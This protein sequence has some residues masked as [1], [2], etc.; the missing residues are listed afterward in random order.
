[1]WPQCFSF[2]QHASVSNPVY[3]GSSIIYDKIVICFSRDQPSS[4]VVK[5]IQ[6]V[7]SCRGWVQEGDALKLQPNPKPK[8]VPKVDLD[9]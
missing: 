2:G 5:A 3:V 8:S 9:Q 7:S 1:M 6:P 4:P